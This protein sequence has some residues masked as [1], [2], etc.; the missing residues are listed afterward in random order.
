M[1]LLPKVRQSIADLYPERGNKLPFTG[2]T[3]PLGKPNT[4]G[5]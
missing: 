1:P 2:K 3:L 4:K 5:S